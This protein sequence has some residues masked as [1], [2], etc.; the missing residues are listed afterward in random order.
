MKYGVMENVL[1]QPWEKIFSEAKKLGFDGLELSVKEDYA[2]SRLWSLDGQEFIEASVDES[3]IEVCSLCLN[4]L[5]NKK[6]SLASQDNSERNKGIEIVNE[7]VEV[8]KIVGGKVVLVPFFESA[9]ISSEDAKKF[10]ITGLK[11]CVETA[12]VEDVYL[13]IESTLSAE[14]TLK[15]IESVDSTYLK[16]YFDMGNAVWL[17]YD[18]VKEIET[19]GEEIIQVH[20]RDTQTDAGDKALGEG[21]VDLKAALEALRRIDYDGY[22]VLETPS[23]P[24]PI[25]AAEANLKYLK[26][27]IS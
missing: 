23:V 24:D 15:I 10:L 12:E 8:C 6:F 25:K 9:T 19:L 20:I 16:V 4:L 18:P 7:A 17:G 22:L 13:G 3:E 11:E 27:Q 2:G 26:S 5:N 21:K 1:K 14:D